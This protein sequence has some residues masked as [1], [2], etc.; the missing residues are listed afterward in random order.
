[1]C[2]RNSQCVSGGANTE[3][4]MFVYC[5]GIHVDRL[6]LQIMSLT[7]DTAG[8]GKPARDACLNRIGRLAQGLGERPSPPT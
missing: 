8:G 4:S 5:R 2:R 6:Q 1:M 7:I 3:K